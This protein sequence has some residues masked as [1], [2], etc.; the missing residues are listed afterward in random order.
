VPLAD[1]PKLGRTGRA[2]GTRKLVF[3]DMPN[4]M[5]YQL[6]DRVEILAVVHAARQW[7]KR[8]D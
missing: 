1:N 7:P 2:K 6:T 5:V 8:F 3:S 4:I